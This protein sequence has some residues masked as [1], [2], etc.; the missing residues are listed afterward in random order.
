MLQPL[1]LVTLA[2]AITKQAPSAAVDAADKS[3]GLLPPKSTSVDHAVEAASVASSSLLGNV[4]WDKIVQKERNTSAPCSLP[5]IGFVG[6]PKTGS[7]FIQ[8]ALELYAHE[9]VLPTRNADA[10]LPKA[11]GATMGYHHASAQIWQH[12]FG[13]DAWRDAFT[14]AL[15]RDPWSRLVS[16]W[17]F[18][19][20]MHAQSEALDGG[21][22]TQQ[23][24][25][26]AVAD[27]DVSIKHFREW[28]RY[29]HSS[30]PP[31][32]KDEYLVTTADALGN[33]NYGCFNAS[34][35]SW[36]V[37]EHCEL[38][39]DEIIK[40]EELEAAWPTLQARVC[41]LHDVSYAAAKENPAM[42]WLNHPSDHR[43][44]SEYY[45]AET[46]AIVG[47]YH[48]ADIRRFGYTPP[49]ISI[50]SGEQR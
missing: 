16:H 11:L 2:T 22:L 12:S 21:L 40:L 27:E 10:T 23:E 42:R 30:T 39:L 34:Q 37:D 9:Q 14:F 41:G 33:E 5:S 7:M 45:D 29:A 48:A 1:F 19:L 13:P 17:T 3:S 15:V 35:T 4:I 47:E 20:V 28:I 6:I 49:V 46:A 18:H 36:L 43:P 25:K 44:Y 8:G 24:R 32:S 26:A 50:L 38:L 31:G